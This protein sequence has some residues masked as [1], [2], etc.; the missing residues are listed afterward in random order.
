MKG[1]EHSPCSRHY[2]DY[3]REI[4]HSQSKSSCVLR[5]EARQDMK[6][7]TNSKIK[8]ERKKEGSLMSENSSCWFACVCHLKIVSTSNT[9]G[10]PYKGNSMNTQ[11]DYGVLWRS[12]IR[13]VRES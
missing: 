11:S 9:N 10:N 3:D 6:T 8:K 5:R 12:V 13:A 2:N 1:M 7:L 4:Y